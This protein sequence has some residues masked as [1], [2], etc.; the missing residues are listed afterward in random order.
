MGLNVKDVT[1][2]DF[3]INNKK[4]KIECTFFMVKHALDRDFN[5]IKQLEKHLQREFNR[6]VHHSF[7]FEMKF[8][9]ESMPR[10]FEVIYNEKKKIVMISGGSFYERLGCRA[11]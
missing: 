9:G 1:G 7:A 4:V 11:N 3:Y 2:N 5:K 10:L 6:A 8:K